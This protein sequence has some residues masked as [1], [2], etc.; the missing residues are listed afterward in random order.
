MSTNLR[1]EVIAV[2][3][4]LKL[5]YTYDDVAYK[6]ADRLRVALAH[7]PVTAGWEKALETINAMPRYPQSLSDEQVSSLHRRYHKALDLAEAALKSE[8]RNDG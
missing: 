8:S 1:E 5:N 3:A 2:I 6:N 7:Q 4:D